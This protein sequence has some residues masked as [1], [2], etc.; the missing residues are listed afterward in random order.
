MLPRGA[1]VSDLPVGE[2]SGVPTL[3]RQVGPIT[4][5]K[6]GFQ[7]GGQ[8]FVANANAAP[9]QLTVPVLASSPSAAVPSGTPVT[10]QSNS[11]AAVVT[12]GASTSSLFGGLFTDAEAEA[13]G[14]VTD[15][16]SHL[17]A[18]VVIGLAIWFFFGRKGRR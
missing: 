6:T 17:L 12:P 16:F 3:I 15:P 11:N 13:I 9:A 8:F 5:P 18:I 4:I 10:Q 1:G 14:I 7:S 2:Q